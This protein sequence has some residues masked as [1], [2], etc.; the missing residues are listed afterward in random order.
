M[1]R[2][3]VLIFAIITAALC[4]CGDDGQ[5]RAPSPGRSVSTTATS[6]RPGEF[7]VFV[8]PAGQLAAAMDQE[9]LSSYQ[10]DLIEDGRLTFAEYEAAAFATVDCLERAGYTV[11][12]VP[13]ELEHDRT[14]ATPG[15]GLSARGRYKFDVGAA[16]SERAGLL[17][18]SGRCRA[19]YFD[20]LDLIWA[21]H[22]AP[23]EQDLQRGRAMIGAC[24]RDKGLTIPDNPS[25]QELFVHAWPPDGDGQGQPVAEYWDCA[26]R[27]ADELGLTGFIG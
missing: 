7:G 5:P 19:E 2:I 17:E 20:L 15:P 3:R 10:R 8:L 23:S 24:L 27:A 4:G 18:A 6:T 9:D 12:H 16:S 1:S 13:G 22:T 21:E 25:Q 11:F 14:N 26:K